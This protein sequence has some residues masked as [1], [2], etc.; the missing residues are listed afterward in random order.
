M[1]EIL[2]YMDKMDQIRLRIEEFNY[3]NFN[4]IRIEE[5]NYPNFNHN[6]FNHKW[7]NAI[8]NIFLKKINNQELISLKYLEKN[9]TLNLL[10]KINSDFFNKINFLLLKVAAVNPYFKNMNILSKINFNLHKDTLIII[11]QIA[12]NNLPLENFSYLIKLEYFK[13]LYNQIIA[14]EI[15]KLNF[16]DIEYLK[17]FF[18]SKFN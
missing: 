11:T 15:K 17:V 10:N 3:P 16:K 9:I 1:P 4:H 5:F 13:E 8:K 18:I 6:Y 7:Y 2:K 14:N 12:I